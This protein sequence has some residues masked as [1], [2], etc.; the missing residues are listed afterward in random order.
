MRLD[1]AKIQQLI[2]AFFFKSEIYHGKM[3]AHSRK[4]THEFSLCQFMQKS[5]INLRFDLFEFE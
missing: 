2:R 3:K 5:F 1:V 4:K